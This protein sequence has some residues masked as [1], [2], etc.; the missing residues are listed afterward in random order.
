M[1]REGHE[2]TRRVIVKNA[3]LIQVFECKSI[4]IYN[5]ALAAQRTLVAPHPNYPGVSITMWELQSVAVHLA[6]EKVPDLCGHAYHVFA[7]RACVFSR[8][9]LCVSVCSEARQNSHIQ[10]EVDMDCMFPMNLKVVP[11]AENVSSR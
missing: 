3:G 10:P 11:V 7:Q 5:G 2:T 1:S 6:S 4:S 8:N 9:G